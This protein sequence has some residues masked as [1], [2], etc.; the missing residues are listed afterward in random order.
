MNAEKWLLE[1][2]HGKNLQ[3]N[4]P[5]KDYTTFRAGGEARYFAAPE[6]EEELAALFSVC[7]EHGLEPL[8]V[9]RGSNLLVSD[10]GFDGVV[11]LMRRHFTGLKVDE[12]SGIL[13]A[14]AGVMLPSAASAALEAGFG[15]L[16]FAAG[17]PGTIGGG[18]IMNAGAYGGELKQLFLD[19]LVLS[20]DGGL[21]MIDADQAELGYRTSAFARNRQTVI[22][23]RFQLTRRSRALIKEQMDDYNR[24]RR[25]KQPLE[26]ASAGSTFKRPAGYF[27]GK[28]IEDAGL[29]GFRIGGAQVSEK[30]AGFVINRGGASASEIYELCME[31]Q[32]RVEEAFGVRMELEVQLAGKF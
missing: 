11:I 14:Q 25:E 4:V 27:A 6:T 18:L 12:E 17:I 31:V 8:I 24:R 16:E 22:S 13:T 15:G 9:G 21:K 2:L 3:E 28:L 7:R 20:A 19:A 10:A 26:F 1:A 23:A 32:R 30:H 5:M 29:K